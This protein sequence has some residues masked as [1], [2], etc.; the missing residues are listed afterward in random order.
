MSSMFTDVFPIAETDQELSRL[1]LQYPEYD[2][3]YIA[4]GSLLE[5]KAFF[6]DLYAKFY[7]YKDSNFTMEVK[8]HF[9][10]RVWE[11]YCAVMML[12]AGFTISS[13]DEGPDVRIETLGD[14]IWIEC[15]AP[16]V[17]KEGNEVPSTTF[18]SFRTV[19]TKEMLLRMSTVLDTKHKKYLG[20]LGKI[21]GERDPYVIALNRSAMDNAEFE[22][23]LI[24]RALFG[25]GDL[26]VEVPA[27]FSGRMEDAKVYHM[28]RDFI[29]NKNGSPV[30]MSFFEDP[31][32]AGVSA[33][34]YTKTDVLAQPKQQLGGDC[35]LIRN[36]LAKNPLPPDFFPFL[37]EWVFQDNQ[38]KQISAK[39]KNPSGIQA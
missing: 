1:K 22:I 27:P 34:I 26:A 5:T 14:P 39:C 19:P 33:I 30:S 2:P 36:P 18:G 38:I 35:V 8:I 11:M 13:R 23:P 7:P 28:K 15:V 10:Q 37:D 3:C 24:L 21:V 31:T 20:Y 12:D 16:N 4:W 25:I 32:R 6:D 17:G 9:R 29:D